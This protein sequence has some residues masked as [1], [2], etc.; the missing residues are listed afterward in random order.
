MPPRRRLIRRHLYESGETISRKQR[1]ALGTA[2]LV[3]A[4]AVA[5]IVAM[6]PLT[7]TDDDPNSAGAEPLLPF[8]SDRLSAVEI[9][10]RGNI[11]RLDRDA[12]GGWY[13]HRHGTTD[14][15]AHEHR[16]D[17]AEAE[18]IAAALDRFARAPIAT[19]LPFGADPGDLGLQTPKLVVMLYTDG[20]RPALRLLAGAPTPDRRNRY[21]MI[22]ETASVVTIPEASITGLAA[23]ADPPGAQ[24][25]AKPR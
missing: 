22:M 18:R 3:G 7:G 20:P 17:K 19:T 5:G 12:Q 16:A 24:G 2:L 15:P 1:L 6:P 11:F 10:I 4:V 25:P 21:L 13:L 9:V 8:A 14:D 23:L